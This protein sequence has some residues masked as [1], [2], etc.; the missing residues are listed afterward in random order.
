MRSVTQDFTANYDSVN[1]KIE[2]DTWTEKKD[3][4]AEIEKLKKMKK[5]TETDADLFNNSKQNI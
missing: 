4:N 1:I 5:R 3:E 2:N